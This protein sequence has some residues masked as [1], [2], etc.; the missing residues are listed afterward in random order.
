MKSSMLISNHIRIGSISICIALCSYFVHISH[1]IAIPEF[2]IWTFLAKTASV[3]CGHFNNQFQHRFS[4]LCYRYRC[5]KKNIILYRHCSHCMRMRPF[6]SQLD[7]TRISIVALLLFLLVEPQSARHVQHGTADVLRLLSCFQVA[8]VHF[9]QTAWPCR[10][11][12]LGHFQQWPSIRL[13]LSL[14]RNGASLSVCMCVLCIR[15]QQSST[16]CV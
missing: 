8:K 6:G 1:W 3:H 12:H 11:I 4:A 14:I 16:T 9:N 10:P 2:Y 13:L 15:L 5:P 7:A